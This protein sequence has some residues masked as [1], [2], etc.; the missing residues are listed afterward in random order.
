[1]ELFVTHE[2]NSSAEKMLTQEK[3]TMTQE[4]SMEIIIGI[5]GLW[6]TKADLLKSVVTQTDGLALAGRMLLNQKANKSFQVDV[7][8]H[9]PA[10]HRSFRIAGG[11]QIPEQELDAIA[12]H[13]YTLY[14]IGPGG[15]Q[16]LAQDMM[17]VAAQLLNAGGLAVK[18]ETAGVAYSKEKWQ[19]L[20]SRGAFSLSHAYTAYLKR[21]V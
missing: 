11:E 12:R 6:P 5:P 14:L 21:L 9:D 3:T 1:M 2:V 10:L 15:T 17:E 4:T 20:A 16:S 18:V 13:T 7:Y 8:E 19:F